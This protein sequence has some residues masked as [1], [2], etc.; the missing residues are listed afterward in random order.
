MCSLITKGPILQC[1][2]CIICSHILQNWY[3]ALNRTMWLMWKLMSN[4]ILFR[5]IYKKVKKQ[6]ESSLTVF[7]YKHVLNS[8][9]MLCFFFILWTM[10]IITIYLSTTPSVLKH[11]CHLLWKTYINEQLIF[12]CYYF[13]AMVQ[14]LRHSIQLTFSTQTK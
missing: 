6:S 1:S 8:W 4:K 9:H 12:C 2:A 11:N 3:F 14:F 13:A 10:D 5:E 7:A